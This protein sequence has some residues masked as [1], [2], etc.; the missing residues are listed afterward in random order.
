MASFIEFSADFNREYV[1][2][3]PTEMVEHFFHSLCL[4]AGINA[5]FTLS[6]RNDHHKIECCFKAFARCLKDAV[7]IT[8]NVVSSTKGIL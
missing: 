2:D 5:H 4:N 7:K 3:L 8:S 1:G 6:G